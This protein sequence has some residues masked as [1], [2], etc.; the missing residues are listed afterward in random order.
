MKL[1]YYKE[2]INIIL[3]NQK[4]FSTLT[5]VKNKNTIAKIRIISHQFYN[6]TKC[7]TIPK[8]L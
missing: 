2:E 8:T 4:Y 6:E 5:S 7:R 1:I 3:K